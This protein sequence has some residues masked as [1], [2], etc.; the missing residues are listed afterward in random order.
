V[1]A[2][3]VGLALALEFEALGGAWWC[4]SREATRWTLGWQ[5]R[6]R[7]LWVDPARHAAMEMAVCRRSGH[8]VDLGGRCVAFDDVDFRNGSYVPNSGW[9]IRHGGHQG[10]VREAAEYLG[11]GNDEFFRKRVSGRA[12]KSASRLWSGGRRNRGWR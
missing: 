9:P 2:G 3:P 12:R 6:R 5:M 7:R 8:V 4:S 1:G 10:V 11:C